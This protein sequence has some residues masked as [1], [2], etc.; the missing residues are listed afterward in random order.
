SLDDL[1]KL[2]ISL[3]KCKPFVI[4]TDH[5]PSVVVLDSPTLITRTAPPQQLALFEAATAA[6]AGE[7]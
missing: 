5:N 2:R 1:R 4:T 7:L 3:R 6:H